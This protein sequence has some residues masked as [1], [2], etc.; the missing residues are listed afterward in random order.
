MFGA[1][2][3]YLVLW[4]D[5][6]L[7]MELT[8][9]SNN[10]LYK[11]RAMASLVATASDTELFLWMIS[12]LVTT[13]LTHKH[14]NKSELW[15]SNKQEARKNVNECWALVKVIRFDGQWNYDW[16]NSLLWIGVR[17]MTVL[18]L[19]VLLSV[20]ISPNSMSPKCKIAA[21]MQ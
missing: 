16:K 18:L 2:S 11:A 9:Q 10:L 21:K 4:K 13:L 17:S 8:N 1:K 3:L 14:S 15:M 19:S 7:L 5:N 6:K 20:I 12:P